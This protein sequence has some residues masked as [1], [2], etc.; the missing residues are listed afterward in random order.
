MSRVPSEI[1]GAYVPSFVPDR[2]RVR[3]VTTVASTNQVALRN[4][5]EY[6]IFV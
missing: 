3:S 5:I 2:A 1:Q 4:L 6:S